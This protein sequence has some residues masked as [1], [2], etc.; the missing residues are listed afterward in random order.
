MKLDKTELLGILKAQ[1]D[2][3]AD[4]RVSGLPEQIDTDRDADAL[5]GIGLDRETLQ[6]KLAGG[7]LG[8]NV[9]P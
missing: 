3:D 8:G 1:G 2:T 4:S 5:A 7:S 9:R 6:A